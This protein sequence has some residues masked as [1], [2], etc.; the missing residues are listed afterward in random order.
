M[1]SAILAGLV[2]LTVAREEVLYS[3]ETDSVPDSVWA[4]PDGR[5]WALVRWSGDSC[6]ILL[7]GAE[8]GP[9]AWVDPPAFSPVGSA[10]GFSYATGTWGMPVFSMK[11]RWR[12][13]LKTE[14]YAK[15]YGPYDEARGPVFSPDGS[16]WGFSFKLRDSSY[17]VINGAEYGPYDNAWAPGFSPDGKSWG[18]WFVRGNKNYCN[19]TGKE[20]GPYDEVWGPAF[21]ADGWGFRFLR[22]GKYY[23]L[24]N[25]E[26]RGPYDNIGDVPLFPAESQ[27]SSVY[28]PGKGSYINFRGKEFG[29]YSYTG[30]LVVSPDG[31]SWA[32][33]FWREGMWYMLL[34]GKE[35]GPY[36]GLSDA[37]FPGNGETVFY[38]TTMTE[39]GA[40]RV[41]RVTVSEK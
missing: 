40:F 35:C 34:N 18:F 5:S 27:G 21:S 25:G 23:S 22:D 2:I 36:Y 17:V 4:S 20:Y 24:I 12:L 8:Y 28:I 19:I 39:T 32:A 37:V 11:G 15:K 16:S 13:L 41:L 14:N 29:P 9:Y 31:K 33:R 10:W 26:E 7:N 1:I 6:Y 3:L 38:A 30:N